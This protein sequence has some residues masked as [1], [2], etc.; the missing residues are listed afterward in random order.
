[1]LLIT[2]DKLKDNGTVVV[3]SI[4]RIGRDAGEN[5]FTL[6]YE[7]YLALKNTHWYNLQDNCFLRQKHN[8]KEQLNR[9]IVEERG[10]APP[11]GYRTYRFDNDFRNHSKHNMLIKQHGGEEY[12]APRGVVYKDGLFRVQVPLI[13]EEVLVN[14]PEEFDTVT[15]AILFYRQMIKK[16]YPDFWEALL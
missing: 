6:D 3:E 9:F 15:H 8:Q 14:R 13:E 5:Y 2:E 1:M 10:F 12:K 7:D 16:A 11:D 4:S